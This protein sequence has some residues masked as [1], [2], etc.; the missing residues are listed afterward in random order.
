M[1]S[2]HDAGRPGKEPLNRPAAVDHAALERF[3]ACHSL[4]QRNP[5]HST[6]ATVITTWVVVEPTHLKTM[7]V[8]WDDDYSQYVEKYKMF[9]EKQPATVLVPII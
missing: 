7:K 5:S 6:G 9:Q 3:K 8:T 4:P 2:V 1:V